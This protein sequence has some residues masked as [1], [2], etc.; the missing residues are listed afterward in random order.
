MD[1][2]S[3]PNINRYF[4]KVFAEG[5]LLPEAIIKDFLIVQQKVEAA[6]RKFRIA[7][8]MTFLN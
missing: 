5:E 4:S 3:V 7:A 8:S 6:I 1:E 2:T